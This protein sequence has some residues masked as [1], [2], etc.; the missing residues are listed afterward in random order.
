MLGMYGREKVD[1]R[2]EGNGGRMPGCGEPAE[3]MEGVGEKGKL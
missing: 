3:G 1:R 2:S